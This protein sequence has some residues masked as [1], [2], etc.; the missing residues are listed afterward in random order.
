MSAGAPPELE[1]V[2]ARALDVDPTQRQPDAGVL[3]RDLEGVLAAGART[4]SR[5]GWLALG[6]IV[7]AG[8]ALAVCLA[9]MTAR[10]EGRAATATPLSAPSPRPAPD[11]G[12]ALSRNDLAKRVEHGLAAG[13]PEKA[14][15]EC[16]STIARLGSVSWALAL[17]AQAQLE[18][19]HA[20]E[21][22]AICSS[23]LAQEPDNARA[24]AV[25]ADLRFERVKPEKLNEGETLAPNDAEASVQLEAAAGDARRA[26]KV[27]PK[28]ALA[29]AIDNGANLARELETG[30][31]T[32]LHPASPREF[33]IRARWNVVRGRIDLAL[34]DAGEATRLAP[35][36][37][38]G[39]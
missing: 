34:E 29:L 1:A 27:D 37:A 24:L 17:L 32:L 22:A 13:Q 16:R 31:R 38:G 3:A 39:W 8:A 11:A 5:R 26:L 21:A 20:G 33:L 19:G 15:S 4:G 10:P 12:P 25:R 30:S 28:L 36:R 2:V 6:T 9:A 18:C 23:V 14:L 7:A 35:T